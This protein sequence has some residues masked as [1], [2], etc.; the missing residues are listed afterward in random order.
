MRYRCGLLLLL[1]ISLAGC[2]KDDPKA[3]KNQSNANSK[4]ATLPAI[5]PPLSPV[6]R[7]EPGFKSC[8]QFFPLVPG[9]VAKYVL[10]YSS[11][12]IAD[13]TVVVDAAGE[14]NGRKLYTERSQIVDRSGGM[15]IVQKT[16]RKYACDGDRVLILSE[17]NESNV[18]G[19]QSSSEFQY[20]E[21]SAIMI[22]PA[23]IERKGSTWQIAF[24]STF[25]SAGQPEAKPEA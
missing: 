24:K 16:T 23:A 2:D 17:V 1:I 13:V 12:L 15:E 7:A 18:A 22:E 8:N 25:R 19:N 10:H 21:H 20:R 4:E 6:G 11:G 14:A 9:S 3:N 5:P